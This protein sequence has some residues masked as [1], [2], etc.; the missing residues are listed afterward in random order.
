MAEQE[1]KAVS[2]L[3]DDFGHIKEAIGITD[4]QEVAQRFYL[5]K[6]PKEQEEHFNCSDP[7]R[8]WQGN[9]S[10]T[11]YIGNNTCMSHTTNPSLPD[12]LNL[13]FAH[14][15]RD[16]NQPRTKQEPPSC[17]LMLSPHAMRCTLSHV[18][19]SN[20]HLKIRITVLC[21]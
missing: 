17:P 2:A 12:D 1:E 8:M 13:F 9:K 7:Q 14:F 16:N 6:K 4:L 19:E 3:E 11:G 10:I 21:Y 15:D 5:Q 18:P 20:M